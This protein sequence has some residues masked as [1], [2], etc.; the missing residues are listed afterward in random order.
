VY[1]AGFMVTTLSK[2]NTPP[3][4]VNMKNKVKSILI[5]FFDIKGIVDK[6]IVMAG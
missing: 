6:E 5:I 1:L 3:T 4:Y 2:S